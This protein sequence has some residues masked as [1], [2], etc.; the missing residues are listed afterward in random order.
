MFLTVPNLTSFL[1]E[2]GLVDPDQVVD[3]PYEITEVGRRCRNFKIEQRGGRG[4]FVKQASSRTPDMTQTLARE[5]S[6]Y[7]LVQSQGELAGLQRILPE[8]VDYDPVRCALVLKLLPEAEN[9]NELHYRLRR[10]PVEVGEL[11]GRGLGAYHADATT[12]ALRT[13]A[14]VL[15]PRQVPWIFRLAPGT[16]SPIDSFPAHT[17]DP[18]TRMLA[19]RPALLQHLWL[20]GQLYQFDSLNHGDM[21]WDN[22]VVFP[23]ADEGA[24]DFRVIDWELA[25]LG[26]AAWDLA[27]VFASY[28]LYITMQQAAMPAADAESRSDTKLADATPSMRRFWEVY[29]QTRGLSANAASAYRQ[30]TMGFLAGRLTLAVFEGLINQTLPVDRA[31]QLIELAQ[32]IALAPAQTAQDLLGAEN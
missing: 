3:G 4:L 8:F 1:V 5:A 29:T 15:L 26:D 22:V 23:V 7:S 17:R 24:Y 25:D 28:V 13:I 6:L 21:K 14:Q 32:T 16:L 11:L 30:R 2:R 12:A 18:L 31:E 27:S 19:A 20:I 9:L 10:F